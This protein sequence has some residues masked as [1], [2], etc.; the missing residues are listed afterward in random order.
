[1][2]VRKGLIRIFSEVAPTYET[3][4]HVLTFGLDV[5]WRKK[6]ARQ[7]ARF[8]GK[9]WLD[10]CSGTGE[11]SRELIRLSG[12]ERQIVA[13]DFTPSMLTRAKGRSDLK[14]VLFVL[15]DVRFLPFPDE[16]F[17]LI[18]VSFAMRNLNPRRKILMDHLKEFFRVLKP[19]GIFLNLE[20]SQ[21][22]NPFI[23][24]L[25]HLY[26]NFLVS[27][28][29]KMISGSLSGYAYLSKTIPRFYSAPLFQIILL[30]AGFRR[31][32]YRYL[33]LGISAIHTAQK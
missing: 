26:I 27:P 16:S 13:L 4:N 23:R 3:V 18:T 14:K 19:S 29:G 11:T 33:F 9:L 8:K 28:I 15:G 30:E 2:T 20:T 21:P 7:G 1:M 31:V 22:S 32:E 6:A 5:V 12:S 17:D 24:Q 25:F 10:A